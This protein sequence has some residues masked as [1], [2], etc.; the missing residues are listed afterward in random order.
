[1]S[2]SVDVFVCACVCVSV[3]VFARDLGVFVCMYFLLP[4]LMTL[5]FEMMMLFCL[6][7]M[8]KSRMPT[9]ITLIVIFV[10]ILIVPFFYVTDDTLEE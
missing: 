3:C 6:F 9:G 4:Y 8:Y 5:M 7:N 10:I 1:M 2:V